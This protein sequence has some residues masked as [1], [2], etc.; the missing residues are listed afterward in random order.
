MCYKKQDKE[1]G[2]L[3]GRRVGERE[4]RIVGEN[5]GGEMGLRAGNRESK[6]V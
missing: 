5:D 3:L 6:E 4:G 2:I 1:N